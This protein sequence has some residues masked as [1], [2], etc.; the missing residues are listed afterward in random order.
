MRTADQI[1]TGLDAELDKVTVWPDDD[2]PARE[3]A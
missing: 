1:R 2:A 3:A